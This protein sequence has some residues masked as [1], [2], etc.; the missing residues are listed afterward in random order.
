MEQSSLCQFL[1]LFLLC[2]CLSGPPSVVFRGSIAKRHAA[3]IAY[4]TCAEQDCFAQLIAL[5]LMQSDSGLLL[6]ANRHD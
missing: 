3:S 5:L 6:S 1:L 4:E 2:F